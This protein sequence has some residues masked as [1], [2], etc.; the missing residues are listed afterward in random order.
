MSTTLKKVNV[1]IDG[2]N[3][4][5]AI[6]ALGDQRLKWINLRSLALSFVRPNERLN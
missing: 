6:N 2:F 1:Y 5:H 3:L 4:Y